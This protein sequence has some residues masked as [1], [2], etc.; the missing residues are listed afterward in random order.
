M[1]PPAAEEHLKKYVREV[2]DFPKP[3][4]LFRDITPLLSHSESFL[5]AIDRMHRTVA[6]WEHNGGSGAPR[7]NKIVGIEARGFIFASALAHRSHK[8]FIPIR[9][10][11]KLPRK[12]HSRRF[13]L[14]YGFDELHLHEGDLTA[15]DHVVIVDDVLATGGTAQAAAELVQLTGAQV[16]GLLF[17]IELSALHGRRKLTD[18]RVESILT[19]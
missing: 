15:E 13:N 7:V 16:V 14:E 12:T 19:Y 5:T 6:A 10:P 4:I 18:R 8:G 1:P 9:K 3:G 17:C 2:P 11:G